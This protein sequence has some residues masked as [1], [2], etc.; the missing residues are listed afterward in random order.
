MTFSV[1]GPAG[2]AAAGSFVVTL[3]TPPAAEGYS[4]ASP[5]MLSVLAL[6]TPSFPSF[7][8]IILDRTYLNISFTT[9]LNLLEIESIE[10]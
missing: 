5:P 10:E 9:S 7:P 3:V 8:S 6:T 2:G 4:E 1:D